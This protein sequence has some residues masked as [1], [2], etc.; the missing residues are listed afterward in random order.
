MGSGLAVTA[1][2]S[3]PSR[4]RAA[5]S[6]LKWGFLALSVGLLAWALYSS[7]DDVALALRDVG[8]VSFAAATGFAIVALAFN[9]LSWRAVMRSVG[10][11]APVPEAAS[12]F[13][14]SQV[15]KYV[16]GAVWPV[17][18]QAE[19]AR[20]HGVS[21]SRALTGSIVAMVVGVAMAGAVGLVGVAVSAPGSLLDYWWAIAIAA[22]L[23][24]L[25]VPAVLRRIVAIA[26][27]LLK[28][29]DDIA[30]IS[31]KAIG[32]SAGWSLVNWLALGAQAW[33][34]LRPLAPEASSAFALAT[35]AF[36]LSWLVGFLVVIAPAGI[37]PREIALAAMLS[38]VATGPQAAAVALLSRFAMSIADG[39]GLLVGLGLRAA[40][41]RSAGATSSH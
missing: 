6:A 23:I 40:R 35:G 13:L 12:V 24:V 22:A 10:L 9:T 8:W 5:I 28:R 7:W 30:E 3:P 31:G 27:R 15:G 17:L 19:F 1:A 29:G 18:T 25:L 20:E 14:I 11:N 38:S 4:R 36:A 2:P 33:L 21:R 26:F 39:V 37:G 32:A 16:P 41:S 34:L